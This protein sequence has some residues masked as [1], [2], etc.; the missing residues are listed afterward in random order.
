MYYINN[1]IYC[2]KLIKEMY[3][4]IKCNSTISSLVHKINTTEP[5]PG[6]YDMKY[7]QIQK[8]V[9]TEEYLNL[10]HL[11]HSWLWELTIHS[12]QKKRHSNTKCHA[13]LIKPS[14][15]LW[16]LGSF[17]NKTPHLLTVFFFCSLIT[18]PKGFTFRALLPSV[19]SR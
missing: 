7:E 12:I 2:I 5:F 4:N 10:H 6:V 3:I 18:D 16:A 13:W 19:S 17:T 11:S 1:Q 15:K 9:N 8:H 14:A